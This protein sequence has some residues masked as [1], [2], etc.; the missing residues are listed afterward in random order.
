ME[1][2]GYAIAYSELG[3]KDPWKIVGATWDR[4]F[5]NCGDPG[6]IAKLLA[7]TISARRSIFSLKPGD[8]QRTGWRQHFERDMRHRGW[9]TAGWPF[10]GSR[11]TGKPHPSPIVRA[12]VRGGHLWSDLADVFLVEYLLKQPF[13][14]GVPTTAQTDDFAEA[15]SREASRNPAQL[16]R[17]E[18]E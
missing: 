17:E 2:S 12:L 8:M 18:F 11:Y 10:S 4:Y 1:L 7:W 15:V 3:A 13:A 9:L 16:D 6:A 14:A 5:E